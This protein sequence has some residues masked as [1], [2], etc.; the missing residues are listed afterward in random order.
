MGCVGVGCVETPVHHFFP[1]QQRH[2][3]EW[4]VQTERVGD[5][6]EVPLGVGINKYPAAKWPPIQEVVRL[7]KSAEVNR[8]QAP[9]QNRGHCLYPFFVTLSLTTSRD[10]A[11]V[12]CHKDKN[13]E[14]LVHFPPDVS[15]NPLQLSRHLPKVVGKR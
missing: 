10:L 8:S 9:F 7:S 6:S 2:F 13:K 4:K 1:Q 3:S 15:W 11:S 5:M 14:K 12:E